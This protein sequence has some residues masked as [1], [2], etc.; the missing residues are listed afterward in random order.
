MPAATR[1][2]GASAGEQY[3][4]LSRRWR[5]RIRPVFLVVYAVAAVFFVVGYIWAQGNWKLYLGVL[6]GATLAI[7]LALRD[8][9]PKYIESWRTGQEGER[10]TAKWLA[11]LPKSSWHCWHDLTDGAGVN[12]DHIVLGAPGLFLLDS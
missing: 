2:A 4:T 5:R 7:A 1:R 12:I 8:S 3:R 11:R 10:M 9:P 6:A